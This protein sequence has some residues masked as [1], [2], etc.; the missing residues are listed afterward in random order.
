MVDLLF[1]TF[2]SNPSLA[3]VFVNEQ[4]E[5]QRAGKGDYSA[6]Y[7]DFLDRA[8][9]VIVD[10][11]RTGEFH[12]GFDVSLLRSFVLGGLRRLLHEWAEHPE[13]IKLDRI[14]ADVKTFLRHGLSPH[15]VI[16]ETFVVR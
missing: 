7:T 16:E 2:A 8:E 15:R 14:R 6:Y 12:N 5:V 10:G 9:Q 11:I 1:D 3:I 4:Q 13:V